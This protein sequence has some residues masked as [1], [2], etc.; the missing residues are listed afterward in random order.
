ME[1]GLAPCARVRV[2]LPDLF[3]VS[4]GARVC[5]LVF[6]KDFITEVGCTGNPPPFSPA[7]FPC[8]AHVCSLGLKLDSLCRHSVSLR[9]RPKD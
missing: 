2:Y 4:D 3:S 7:H 5:G 6:Q 8:E 1:V 9:Q